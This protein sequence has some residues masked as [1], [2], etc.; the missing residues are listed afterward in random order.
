MDTPISVPESKEGKTGIIEGLYTVLDTVG[1]RAMSPMQFPSR[2]TAHRW[3]KSVVASS[4]VISA[5]AKDYILVHLADFDI[6]NG[7][8]VAIKNEVV[9]CD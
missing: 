1:K 9:I 7:V 4:P 2:E 3:Y 6:F 5:N 8:V